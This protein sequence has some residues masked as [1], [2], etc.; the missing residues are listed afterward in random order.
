MGA[1][2]RRQEGAI[3]TLIKREGGREGAEEVDHVI[4]MLMLI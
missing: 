3:A 1:E 4:N 2:L